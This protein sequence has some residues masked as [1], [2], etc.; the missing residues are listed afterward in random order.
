MLDIGD[1]GGEAR[2]ERGARER[3]DVGKAERL[4]LV[5]QIVAQVLGETAAGVAAGDARCGTKGKRAQ[6]D[7]RKDDGS[8]QDVCDDGAILDGCLLYTSRCV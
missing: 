8:G 4:D 1:I 7:N 5:E 2:D 6:R 3:V